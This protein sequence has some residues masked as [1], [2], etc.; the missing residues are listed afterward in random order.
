M[1]ST[2]PEKPYK[3][4]RYDNDDYMYVYPGETTTFSNLG[5]QYLFS[6]SYNIY[7]NY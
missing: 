3:V 1:G 5:D 7:I 6:I 4:Y 2:N